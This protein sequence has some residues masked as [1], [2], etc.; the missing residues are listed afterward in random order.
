M[1]Q[2]KTDKPDITNQVNKYF[3]DIGPKCSSHKQSPLNKS[4]KTFRRKTL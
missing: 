4:Y 2:F 3:T 1:A